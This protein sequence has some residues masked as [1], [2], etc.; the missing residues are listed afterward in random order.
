VRRRV[1]YEE[2]IIDS[3]YKRFGRRFGPIFAQLF[4]FFVRGSA[5]SASPLSARTKAQSQPFTD[6]IATQTEDFAV[7]RQAD[8]VIY[9]S[10]AR[11]GSEA[12]AHD[13]LRG[14][15]AAEQAGL[16]VLPGYELAA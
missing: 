1:R 2:E 12:E 13:H 8:N 7:A 9:A 6:R 15:S 16:H 4:T 10:A 3:N 11:F 5:L 14:L